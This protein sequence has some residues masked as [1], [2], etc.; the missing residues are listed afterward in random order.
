MVHLWGLCSAVHFRNLSKLLNQ[1]GFIFSHRSQEVEQVQMFKD[2]KEDGLFSSS[3]FASL[4]CGRQSQCYELVAPS[5][6]AF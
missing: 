3:Y 2:V 1:V 6:P 5:I 4:M